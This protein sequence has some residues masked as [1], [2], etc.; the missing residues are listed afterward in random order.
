MRKV[1]WLA[2]QNGFVRQAING[3]TVLIACMAPATAWAQASRPAPAGDLNTLVRASLTTD[4]PVV[5]A[6]RPIWVEFSL[7]SQTENRLTLR[8][9]EVSVEGTE[10]SEMG[11]PIEHV[12]SGHNFMGPVLEDEYGER[13]DSRASIR[14]RDK[15]AAIKLA[16]HGTVGIRLDL[17]QHYDSLLRPGKYKLTWQPYNASITSQ[18]LSITVLAE[19]QAVI[20][21][22]L[23]KMTVRFHYDRAPGHVQN[24]IE[25]IEQRFYDN[26]TFNRVIPGGLIQGGDPQGNRRGVRTDSK[27]LKAEFNSVPFEVGTV[28]MCRS[29]AD[30]NSAS[31]QFFICLARQPS[32]DGQQTAFGYLVG[33]DSFET[34]RRI[35]AVPTEKRQGMEDYP[36]KPVFIRAISLENVSNRERSGHVPAPSSQPTISVGSDESRGSSSLWSRQNRSQGA[37]HVGGTT[38][39]PADSS[40]THGETSRTAGR[41]A[42]S[43]GPKPTIDLPGLKAKGRVGKRASSSTRP[44]E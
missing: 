19:R 18:P 20:L 35:A 9:P 32:F 23:G 10:Y 27:R 24:F 11:L 16:P 36:R 38:V 3:A 21:T 17:T 15:V 31:C 22:D 37:A 13:H 7:I 14:P 43:E 29:T 8:V 1:S 42:S 4:N 12:F 40:N 33:D 39:L 2:R 44:G 26:L 28:G 6:G 30:P 5:Q 41:K 25:L 34:L